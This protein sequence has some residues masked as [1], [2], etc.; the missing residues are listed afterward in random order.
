[1]TM[2]IGRELCPDFFNGLNM[3]VLIVV[4]TMKY[5]ISLTFDRKNEC[6]TIYK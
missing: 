4:K 1:M 2:K 3:T 5:V 6:R